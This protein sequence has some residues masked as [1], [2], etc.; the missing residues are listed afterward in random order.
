QPADAPVPG[1]VV[2]FLRPGVLVGAAGEPAEL[3]TGLLT[4]PGLA[5]GLLGVP[6]RLFGV[7]A[8]LFG[9]AAGLLRLLPRLLGLV[10][11]RLHLPT[12]LPLQ[13]LRPPPFRLERPAGAAR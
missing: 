11:L 1:A 7:A 6:P 2:A 3:V 8:G 4:R 9:V 5:A 13:P 10:F 12:Q